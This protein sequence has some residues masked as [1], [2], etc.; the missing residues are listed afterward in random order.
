MSRLRLCIAVS[1]AALAVACCVVPVSFVSFMH[2]VVLAAVLSG[3]FAWGL[4]LP[5][6]AAAALACALL[7]IGWIVLATFLRRA[8]D[9][10]ADASLLEALHA[11]VHS[12]VWLTAAGLSAVLFAALGDEQTRD[13]S[14]TFRRPLP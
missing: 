7:A 5:A 13:G 4:G 14:A 6:R 10:S 9:G 1:V 11:A 12:R 8:L 2:P 3:L